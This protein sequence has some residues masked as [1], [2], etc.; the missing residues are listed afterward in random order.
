MSVTIPRLTFPEIFIGFVAPVGTELTES[1]KSFGEYF[2][3]KGYNIINIKVTDVFDELQKY[4]EPEEELVDSPIDKRYLSHI[5]YGNQIR[6]FYD[7]DSAL[8]AITL[9]RMM[10][11]RA[12]RSPD[13]FEKNVYLIDQFKRPEEVE[14]FRSIYGRLFFKF[15]FILE[16]ARV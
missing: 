11:I 5:K 4:L 13:N 16:K 8:A 9:S 14:L 12:N 10:H 15:L 1:I 6:K 2:R 7:D 3:N